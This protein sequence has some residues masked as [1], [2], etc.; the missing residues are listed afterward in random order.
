MK[1]QLSQTIRGF[2]ERQIEILERLS[3]SLV[4]FQEEYF[5]LKKA[6]TENAVEAL[7]VYA[8]EYG[9][10]DTPKVKNRQEK[11]FFLIE[12]IRRNWKISVDAYGVR[13]LVYYRQPEQN[14]FISEK[15]FWLAEL[16]K[17]VKSHCFDT[18]DFNECKKAFELL[19]GVQ[20]GER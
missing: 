20:R 6:Y 19:E 9:V 13:C 5:E 4:E 7:T 8:N 17:F 2:V 12:P 14:F 1:K 11:N 15:V 18:E 16:K 10:F 3:D